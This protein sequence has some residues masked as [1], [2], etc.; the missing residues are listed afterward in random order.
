MPLHLP[1]LFRISMSEAVKVVG[2]NDLLDTLETLQDEGVIRSFDFVVEIK[3][4]R[5]KAVSIENFFLLKD[6][7]PTDIKRKKRENDDY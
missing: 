5:D 7:K 4:D 2:D 3:V 1:K 6:Y